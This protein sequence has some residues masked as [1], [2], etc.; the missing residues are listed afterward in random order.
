MNSCE[1]SWS[2]HLNLKLLYRFQVNLFIQS[3]SNIGNAVIKEYDSSIKLFLLRK[4]EKCQRPTRT[5]IWP[6]IYPGSGLATF[7]YIESWDIR[8]NHKISSCSCFLPGILEAEYCRKA[9]N[10]DFDIHFQNGFEFLDNSWICKFSAE[11]IKS[12]KPKWASVWRK[13]LQI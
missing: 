9:F 11:M 10:S 4:L 13:C 6:W 8:S 7:W 12:A 5:L 3:T 1:Q 2:F